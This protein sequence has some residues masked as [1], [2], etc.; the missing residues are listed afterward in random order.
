MEL[1]LNMLMIFRSKK[2]EWRLVIRLTIVDWVH[3]YGLKL[4]DLMRRRLGFKLAE[5]PSSTTNTSF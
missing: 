2:L 5:I 3:N 4:F 1:N